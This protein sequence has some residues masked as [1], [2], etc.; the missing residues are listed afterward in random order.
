[1]ACTRKFR[2]LSIAMS[3]MGPQEGITQ[4]IS[5]VRLGRTCAVA[6]GTFSA[7]AAHYEAMLIFDH[8]DEMGTTAW[9]IQI[10][11]DQGLRA[12]RMV[13]LYDDLQDP[14]DPL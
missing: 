4:Q 7:E 11:D 10:Q 8:Q 12:A 3:N 5:N 2:A 1:M 13:D 6:L 14:H 9:R